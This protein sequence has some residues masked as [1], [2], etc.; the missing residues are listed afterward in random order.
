MNHDETARQGGVFAAV[1]AAI[2]LLVAA[3]TSSSA[4][5]R[6]A[7]VGSSSAGRSSAPGG[8]ASIGPLAFAQ[9]MRAHGIP[10]YPDPDSNGSISKETAQQLGVSD[11]QYHTAETACARLLPNSE[12]GGLTEAEIQEAWNG[13]RN[14]A[15]CMR[16]R[17]V[18]SWPDPLD[19][20]D[21]SP[22]FYLQNKIDA[23]APQIVTTI[24]ACQH[25]IPPEDRSFGGSPGG[26]RMCPGD[27]PNPATQH[28]AC[29]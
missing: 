7:S 24:H 16:S 5:S 29:G 17:G 11:F 26:V 28:G 3:C 13:T 14:F 18:P 2:V 6:V 4:G 20:G 15:Q 10:N 25:L 21:G 1:L 12:H 9:C 23:N 8:S 22:V 27:K 19:G